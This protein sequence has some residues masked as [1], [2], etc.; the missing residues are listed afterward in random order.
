MGKTIISKRRSLG[1]GTTSS[2]ELADI[3]RSRFSGAEAYRFRVWGTLLQGFLRPWIQKANA[4]LDLGAGH[5]EFINQVKAEKK[6]AMDLNPETGNHLCKD[7]FFLRQS[8]A[9]PWG[10]PKASLDLVF[11]SNFF[12]H[13]PDKESLAKTL[14][15]AHRTL[16]PGGKLVALGP[17][18]R[19]L[20]GAY[21]DFWDH[22]LPLTELSLSE[23]GRLCGFT[24][25][26]AISAT[27]PYSMS[28]GF[29]P[30]LWSVRLYLALP[31]LWRIFGK[32]FLV[33]MRK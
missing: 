3:Y 26:K 10:L 32:Q 6:W 4:I 22:Y 2:Q 19:L 7:I 30:P 15:Q 25:E 16:R 24:I 29:Q 31:F 23:V 20:P 11:T 9:E 5:G 17:N 27:L 33:V 14:R 21:W 8:C 1:S 28:Q 13:L 12:E 18:I